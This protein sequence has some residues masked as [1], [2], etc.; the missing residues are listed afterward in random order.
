MHHRGRIE[1]EVRSKR[2]LGEYR[3]SFGPWNIHEGADAFGPKVRG[4]VAFAKKFNL[5]KQLGFDRVQ[6]SQVLRFPDRANDDMDSRVTPKV[7]MQ[8][9]RRPSR[10]LSVLLA[11][12]CVYFAIVVI[13]MTACVFVL[14][15]GLVVAFLELISWSF[16]IEHNFTISLG[17]VSFFM[18][19]TLRK[20]DLR[21]QSWK[22]LKQVWAKGA[23]LAALS[24]GG[25]G[26]IGLAPEVK[27]ELI[28]KILSLSRV[29][30][31]LLVSAYIVTL[32]FLALARMF[33]IIGEASTNDAEGF[34]P[35]RWFV[36]AFTFTWLG[37]V[38]MFA[39]FFDALLLTFY[40]HSVSA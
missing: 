30:V 22:S 35:L 7:R 39:L 38:G 32:A 25:F 37:T 8:R 26:F 15:L 12:A 3:F 9:P 28:K 40:A 23:G 21:R 10:W 33:S 1:E 19:F 5:H 13:G 16:I 14:I 24:V 4:S 27:G 34:V 29:D 31:R 11:L 20:H 6:F 2:M 17:F 36:P 18:Q